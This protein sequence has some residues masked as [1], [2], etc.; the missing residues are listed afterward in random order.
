MSLIDGLSSSF[1]LAL[2][3]YLC[4]ESITLGFGTFREPGVGFFPF[5]AGVVLGTLSLTLLMQ[6]IFKRHG[7]EKSLNLWREVRWDK[8]ILVVGVLFAYVIVLNILGY[9]IT[10][11]AFLAFVSSIIKKERSLTTFAA[12]IM[13]SLLSYFIFHVWLDVE[14]PKGYLGF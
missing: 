9:I 8:A 11:F 6:S 12:A 10:T 4:V 13:V 14:L 5:W 1:W 7:D 2:S 3:I